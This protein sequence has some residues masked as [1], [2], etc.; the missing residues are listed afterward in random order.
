[1]QDEHS[2]IQM[3]TLEE[4]CPMKN[5]LGIVDDDTLFRIVTCLANEGYNVNNVLQANKDFWWDEQI[6]DAIKN[7]AGPTGMNALIYNSWKG[8][9]ERV[10]WLLKRTPKLEMTLLHGT[11]EGTTALLIACAHGHLEIAQLLM[12]RSTVCPD[13]GWEYVSHSRR[14]GWAIQSSCMARCLREPERE[15]K[16][17]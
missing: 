14:Q 9:L 10:T 13:Q 1:M 5:T 8:N 11:L 17:G 7:T 4:I 6:W 3:H 15:G 12:S 16:R 2:Y